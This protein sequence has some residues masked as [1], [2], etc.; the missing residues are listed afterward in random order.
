MTT[1]IHPNPRS[2]TTKRRKAQNNKAN[3]QARAEAN[4]RRAHSKQEPTWHGIGKHAGVK[5]GS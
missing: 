5:L 1:S 4:R 2:E 3:H